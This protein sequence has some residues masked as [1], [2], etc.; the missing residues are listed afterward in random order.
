[1]ENG[2]WKLENRNSKR[3]NGNWKMEIGLAPRQHATS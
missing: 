2:N 3:E 1:M